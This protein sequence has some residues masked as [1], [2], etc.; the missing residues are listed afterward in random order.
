MPIPY[1]DP[2][3]PKPTAV[4]RCAM[5]LAAIDAVL[6][7][8]LAR[9]RLHE[10]YAADAEDAASA[11]GFAAL[12][13]ATFAPQGDP[14]KPVVWLH[15]RRSLQACG[16]LQ[17]EGLSELGATPHA[18]LFVQAEGRKALLQA[19]L[20]AARCKGLGAVVMQGQGRIPELD[21]TASR[22]LLLAAQGSGVTLLLLHIGA[23]PVP[24][25]A[26]TR[27]SAASAPSRALAAQAPGAPAFD[28]ELLRQ[29]SGPSGMR[30][31][32]EWD[33]E[34]SMFRDAQAPGAVVSVPVRGS[35]ADTGTGSLRH[36][37]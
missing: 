35:A 37:A 36:V 8:G 2:H 33:R 20:D 11:A 28:I 34:R 3:A 31:R 17:A 14:A 18:Y 21:L 23:E 30:W 4:P 5:G 1:P 16:A 15:E 26:E 10:I 6:G 25:A 24:S 13:A 22:K 32:V 7:G 27:W 29:R 9:G 12:L 19:C